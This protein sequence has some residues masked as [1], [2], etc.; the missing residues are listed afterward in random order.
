MFPF[1]KWPDRFYTMKVLH[2]NIIDK[3]ST[4]NIFHKTKQENTNVAN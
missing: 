3:L 4:K 1:M 2:D